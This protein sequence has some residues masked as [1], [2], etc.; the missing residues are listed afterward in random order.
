[1]IAVAGATRPRRMPKA[2]DAKA[3]NGTGSSFQAINFL[4]RRIAGMS[5]AHSQ[6][7]GGGHRW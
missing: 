5:R 6:E 2:A 3:V 7:S 4:R 1:M